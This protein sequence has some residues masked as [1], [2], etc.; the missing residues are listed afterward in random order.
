[1]TDAVKKWIGGLSKK[2][3]QQNKTA[4][5]IGLVL[6]GITLLYVIYCGHPLRII[7]VAALI[8]VLVWYYN[9]LNYAIEHEKSAPPTN[10]SMVKDGP[11]T[12][13]AIG[14]RGFSFILWT[15]DIHLEDAV[16]LDDAGKGTW[17][18]YTMFQNVSGGSPMA[19]Q[20][21]KD[22]SFTIGFNV[23]GFEHVRWYLTSDTN[24]DI[25]VCAGGQCSDADC[26]AHYQ[27]V[28]LRVNKDET[29]AARWVYDETTYIVSL[30]DDPT[31][32]LYLEITTNSGNG[33]VLLRDKQDG[34]N[35][36]LYRCN[37]ED[38]IWL[39]KALNPNFCLG[40]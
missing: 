20:K 38:E 16:K 7:L 35:T 1:M 37:V 22:G 39:T 18:K 4:I 13:F 24:T 15:G 31:K 2:N 8:A 28:S 25:P 11:E 3:K 12:G 33:D 5:V 14:D 27:P 21:Y 9:A 36:R 6:L 19:L 34:A 10:P 40:G 30:R 32:N 17:V 26:A 23:Q 29:K